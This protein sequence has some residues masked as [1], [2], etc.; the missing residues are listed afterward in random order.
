MEGPEVEAWQ[1]VCNEVLAQDANSEE[2]LLV[3][4]GKFGPDTKTVTKAV[5]S[6]LGVPAS[7][8]VDNDTWVA[9]L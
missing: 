7:G 2:E 8:V 1:A 5:Q 3:T 4:D 9:V 6:I